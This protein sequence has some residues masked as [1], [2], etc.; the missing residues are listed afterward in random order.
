MLY[1]IGDSKVGDLSPSLNS[2]GQLD[3]PLHRS[4][5]MAAPAG[6]LEDL[7][8]DGGQNLHVAWAEASEGSGSS[9]SRALGRS[10]CWEEVGSAVPLP[11]WSREGPLGAEPLLENLG[12]RSPWG[13]AMCL[14]PCRSS[15]SQG[16]SLP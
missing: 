9:R 16:T 5:G 7:P 15:F 6:T 1:W 2:P 8:R 3:R 10:V 11:T 12:P 13:H 4:S 14:R